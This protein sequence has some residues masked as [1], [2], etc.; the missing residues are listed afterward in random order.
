MHGRDPA[1]ARTTRR[2]TNRLRSERGF[3]LPTTMLMLLAAFATVSVGVAATINVQHGTIRDQGTKA[4]LQ[5]AQTGVN[6][7]LLQYNRITP[8]ANPCAPVTSGSPAGNGWC[9]AVGPTTDVNGGTFTY[10]VHPYD[11]LVNGAPNKKILEVVGTGQFGG[12]TRRIMVSAESLAQ[13]VFGDASVKT[14]TG[15]TLDSNSVIHA[16]TATNGSITLGS[17]AQQCGH[18]TVGIGQGLFKSGNAGYFND[19]GCATPTTSVGQQQLVLPAVNQGDAATNNDNARLF[20]QDVISGNKAD[21]CFNGLNGN[22]QADNRCGPRE[23]YVTNNSAVTLSGGTYSL[24]SLRMRSN[25]S[26]YIAAG[27]ITAIYF[28]SPEHCG[29]SGT[30]AVTQLDLDSN[31]RITSSTGTPS[32]LA[33]L[34]VGS[35]ARQTIINLDSNTAVGTTCQQNYILY[36]PLTHVEMNSNSTYCG[37]L[38]AKDLHMDSNADIKPASNSVDLQLPPVSPHYS[39]PKFVECSVATGVTPNSG[40]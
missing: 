26:L 20:S 2:F 21:A 5:L 31:T 19:T 34:F 36:A 11:V 22:G 39:N 32:N 16:V 12:A 35:P 25:S 33:M 10:Q 40:C 30:G 1:R 8:S 13:N 23:L 6:Q 24:C 18:A 27:H 9:P 3:A 17:N 28:D 37:A 15:I 7:A 4:A 14:S 29:Y 38:A